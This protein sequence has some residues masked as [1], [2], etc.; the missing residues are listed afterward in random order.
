M[1]CIPED[2]SEFPSW[3]AAIESYVI[4]TRSLEAVFDFKAKI[5]QGSFG[6][7]YKAQVKPH[8]KIF[9]INHEISAHLNNA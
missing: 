1:I 7:V 4:Q 3:Q 5:G 6:S 8:N 2:Q 9:G